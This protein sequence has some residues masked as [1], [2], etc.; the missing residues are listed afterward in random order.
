MR[1]ILLAAALVAATACAKQSDH[2]K[3]APAPAT[4]ADPAAANIPTVTVDDVDHSLAA[5]S[6]TP[7]DANGDGTRKKMGVIPGAVLLTDEDSYDLEL[8]PPDKSKELV[9]Y[10][11]NTHCGASHHAASRAILAGY[12]N[13]K[14]MP[15]GIA[16]WVS[17]G[18][19]TQAM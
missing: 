2:Q 8:L 4:Q 13:V 18:K 3:S 14:V 9:F 5:G 1:K 12:T 16:G 17:A 6:C 19:K 10:C 11:A 7:V 15:Q